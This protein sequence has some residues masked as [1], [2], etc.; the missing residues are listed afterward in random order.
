[1]SL[2][3]AKLLPFLLGIPLAGGCSRNADERL[4]QIQKRQSIIDAHVAADEKRASDLRAEVQ[5]LEQKIDVQRRCLERQVCWTQLARVNALIAKE[6]AECNRASANWFACDAER[7][8]TKAEGTGLGCLVGWGFAV[9]TGGSVAPAIAIG[10]GLGSE[11]G[12]SH[13]EGDCMHYSRP[14]PCGQRQPVFTAVALSTLQLK[15][16]PTCEP[17]PPECESL[18]FSSQ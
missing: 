7:T 16:V 14:Q 15:S 8:R 13:T 17:I 5:Q 1:M 6:L 10:C 4:A 12:A 18:G 11:H 2:R 3:P 9:A